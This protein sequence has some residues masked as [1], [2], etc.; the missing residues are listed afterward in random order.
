MDPPSLKKYYDAVNVTSST[1]FDNAISVSRFE[2][3]REWSALGKPVDRNQW[4]VSFH[5]DDR[6]AECCCADNSSRD[7]T[8]PTVNACTS[9]TFPALCYLPC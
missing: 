8:V 3:E 7:M 2:V 6:W 4:F 1:F 5:G 9:L